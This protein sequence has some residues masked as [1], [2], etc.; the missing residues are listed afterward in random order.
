[1]DIGK[2]FSF[3]FEDPKWITK[4]L[5]GGLVSLVPI[6]NFAVFGYLLKTAENVA[7]DHPQP[8]P[9]WGEFG[10]HFMRGLHAFVIS[11]VYA[12]PIIVIYVLMITVSFAGAAAADSSEGAGAMAGFAALCLM[13]ILIIVAIVTGFAVY[14]AFARYIAN[15]NSLSAALQFGPVLASLRSNFTTW[16][17]LY[18]VAILASFVGGLGAIACGVGLLLTIPYSYAVSAHALGQTIKQLNL[19]APANPYTYQ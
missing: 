4:M 2:A 19:T 8:L 17:V 12:I 14:A 9:E 15:N 3:V 13:P 6:L 16:L 5:I 7:K 18:L 1:M 10:D 11:I